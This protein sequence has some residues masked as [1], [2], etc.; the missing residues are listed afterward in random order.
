MSVARGGP[1]IDLV[2][3]DD[4]VAKLNCLE[5]P[6]DFLNLVHALFNAK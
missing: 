2:Y 4:W 3:N 5:S 6:P 1:W